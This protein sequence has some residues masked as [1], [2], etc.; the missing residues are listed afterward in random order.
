MASETDGLDGAL[1]QA[2]KDA[3]SPIEAEAEQLS[4]LAQEPLLG[5]IRRE[6]VV[7]NRGR[8][9]GARNKRTEDLASYILQRHRNP[10]IAAAQIVD[11]PIPELAKAL[12]CDRLEA[13]EYWRKCVELV[14]RYTLQAMPQAVKVDASTAG[15][16]MVI[17]LNAPR[18]G[19]NAVP[20]SP[21]GLDINIVENQQV[22]EPV[23]EASH[24][25]PSHEVS[26]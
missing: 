1:A 9:P 4:L 21:H 19:D 18:P 3:P 17:N 25:A 5:E 11:T 16:L 12:N 22:S 7:V 14:A 6:G 2:I 24:G 8:P 26:K 10:I 13:A 23:A 20:L 15:T